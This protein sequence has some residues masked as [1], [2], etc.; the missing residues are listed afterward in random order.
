MKKKE[1]IKIRYS[2]V[3]GNPTRE[4]R[5][6]ALYDGKVIKVTDYKVTYYK[7][8]KYQRLTFS[9]TGH[10]DSFQPYHKGFD[11]SDVLD[12]YND[13]ANCDRRIEIMSK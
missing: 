10:P 7:L 5:V 8:D 13:T 2:I 4:Q 12:D 11:Y 6:E 3:E 1:A 9:F